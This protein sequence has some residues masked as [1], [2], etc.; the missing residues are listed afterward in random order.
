MKT[1]NLRLS[2]SV[3]MYVQTQISIWIYIY[4]L[5]SPSQRII[6]IAIYTQTY[7]EKSKS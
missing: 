3:G 1:E 7:L 2:F 5:K 6:F 4:L